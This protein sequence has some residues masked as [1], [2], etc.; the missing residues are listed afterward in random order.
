[1]TIPRT[2]VIFET[3]ERFIDI[4]QRKHNAYAKESLR[5]TLVAHWR[6]DQRK[7][8]Q[9]GNNYR[10]Q[11]APRSRAYL[12][13]KLRRFGHQIDFLWSGR[14]RQQMTTQYRGPRIGG[15]A[16]GG[17]QGLSGQLLMRFPFKGG[18]GRSRGANADVLARMQSEMSRWS[19]DEAQAATQNYARGYMARV[20]A[21][22]GGLKRKRY[23]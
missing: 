18:T 20:N 3:T 11:H 23:G 6:K 1:M 10:Y 21:W 15:A 13:R 7:H 19:D 5:D 16:E 9:A 4:A 12:K 14:S 8:F 17:K 2:I 22:R